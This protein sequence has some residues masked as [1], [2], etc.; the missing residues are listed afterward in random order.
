MLNRDTK[1]AEERNEVSL[2]VSRCQSYVETKCMN[3]GL[4]GY[5]N[6][7]ILLD[8]VMV[9]TSLLR[10]DGYYFACLP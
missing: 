9:D 1:E 7:H 4:G 6:V 2:D 10:V 8:C 3:R 5:C